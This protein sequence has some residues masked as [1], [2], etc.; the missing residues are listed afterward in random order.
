MT[1]PGGLLQALGLALLLGTGAAPA[2]RAQTVPTTAEYI[3]DTVADSTPS[4]PSTPLRLAPASRTF[5]LG[6]AAALTSAALFDQTIRDH[7]IA[8]HSATLDHLASTIGPL[9]T[10]RVL[11]PA[12]AGS[13]VVTRIHGAPDGAAAILRAGIGY[14]VADGVDGALKLAAGRARPRVTGAP[15]TFHP[16]T[17][18]GDW[19]SFPSGHATHIASIVA[20]AAEESHRPWVAVVGYGVVTLVDWQRIYMDQHWTSDVVAGTALGI[21]A[22][23]TTVRWLEARARRRRSST[24]PH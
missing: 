19:H 4:P 15:W 7:A 5:W 21:V 22:S 6:T 16:F 14:A 13:Y 10:A 20:A 9:G 24:P 17:R 1:H 23:T 18:S 8:H 12:L 11:I 2:L 3:A